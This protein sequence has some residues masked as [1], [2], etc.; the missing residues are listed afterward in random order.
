MPACSRVRP[1][2]PCL[3]VKLGRPESQRVTGVGYV[4]VQGAAGASSV[5]LV[6]F[7]CLVQHLS[8]LSP[9]L[10]F[11]CLLTDIPAFT[12]RKEL[13]SLLRVRLCRNKILSHFF[14]LY[15]F[16]FRLLYLTSFCKSCPWVQAKGG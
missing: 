10:F 5:L 14:F 3:K 12:I 1:S 4:Q 7:C 9:C 13:C 11:M 6:Q 16:P 15:F 2:I 8:T